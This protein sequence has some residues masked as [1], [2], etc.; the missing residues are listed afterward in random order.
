MGFIFLVIINNDLIGEYNTTI[1]ERD[2]VVNSGGKNN[3]VVQQ[4]I[5]TLHGLRLNI[6]TS[7]AAYKQQLTVSK[8]QL[9]ER[10]KKFSSE[11]YQLPEKEKLLRAINRQQQI[12]EN[13]Y[14]LLLQKREEAAIN[15]A[16]T[17]PSIKIVDYAITAINPIAPKTKIVYL[18]SFVLGLLLPFGVLSI[19]FMLDTKI[20][21]KND[22]EEFGV[23]FPVAGEI[24]VIKDNKNHLFNDPN[25][26]TVLAEAFRILSSNVNFMLPSHAKKGAVI[27]CTSSIKAEGKTFISINLSLALSSLNK[28]V[29]LI[30]AD[31]RNPQLHPYLGVDKKQTGLSNYLHGDTNDWKDILIK[32]FPKHLHHDTLLSGEIPPNPPYLLS[33][34]RYEALLEEAKEIYD[35]IVIDTAP[36]VLVTD[37]LLISK[38]SDAVLYVVRANY[39]EKELINHSIEFSKKIKLENMAYVINSVGERKN[40]YGYKYGYNYGYGYGY[41]EEA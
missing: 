5:V 11:V 22:I 35:Y 17:E 23:H 20:H 38:F 3:P 41:N 25:D 19:I 24:P 6:D 10:N 34:G 18:G 15:L 12:K 2:K 21:D 40:G 8:R 30:G 1:L 29:L 39:T 26:R 33:N 28:K 27:N 13:L 37:T 4:L 31:L 14:L 36:T 9:L 16:V 32:G 7:I